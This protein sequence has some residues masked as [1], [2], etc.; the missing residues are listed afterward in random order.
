MSCTW[1]TRGRSRRTVSTRAAAAATIPSRVYCAFCS[2]VTR[3]PVG[4]RD[5][6]AAQAR[7]FCARR[8]AAARGSLDA[9]ISDTTATPSRAW[10]VGDAQL[11]SVRSRFVDLM[12]PVQSARQRHASLRY[13]VG[14]ETGWV[15]IATALMLVPSS[16]VSMART[17]AIPH[18]RPG[19]LTS[20]VLV[21]YTAPRPT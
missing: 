14:E 20:F 8:E 21:A 5:A 6:A 13:G 2:G 4:P 12:P 16:T 10:P 3:K 11:C 9:A 7:N 19:A 17:P 18:T 15:P 1:C